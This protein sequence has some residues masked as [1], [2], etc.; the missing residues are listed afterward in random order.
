[1]QEKWS[2]FTVFLYEGGHATRAQVRKPLNSTWILGVIPGGFE[3]KMVCS[4][5]SHAHR[6]LE[7][8]SQ[9]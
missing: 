3:L 5:V 6:L 9:T 1:M 4:C 7:A 8:K 2:L